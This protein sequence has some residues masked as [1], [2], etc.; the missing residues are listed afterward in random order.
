MPLTLLTLLHSPVVKITFKSRCLSDASSLC[1]SS[2]CPGID[3]SSLR[4]GTG[5]S[6]GKVD[7]S[8]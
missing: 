6:L 7:G 8:R 1:F 3:A 4:A 2:V 5:H